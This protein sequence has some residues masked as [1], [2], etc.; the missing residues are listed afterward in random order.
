M[1]VLMGLG[2]TLT[3]WPALFVDGQCNWARWV[4]RTSARGRPSRVAPP[5]GIR[6]HEDELTIYDTTLGEAMDWVVYD[7]A[8]RSPT[9]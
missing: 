4:T 2:H 6:L 7:C 8:T 9:Q 1:L 5:A 3:C